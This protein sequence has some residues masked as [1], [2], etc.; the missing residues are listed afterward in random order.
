MINPFLIW[1]NL[2][3]N[4]IEYIDTGLPIRSGYYR[5]RR[6]EILLK[7]HAL[8][9]E[10][11]LELI[12][13]YEGVATIEEY[14]RS[15]GLPPDIAGYLSISLCG[16]R[17]LYQHQIKALDE[18]CVNGKNIVLATGTGSGKTECFLMP[19]L[20][21]LIEE[22]QGWES[23]KTKSRKRGI[24]ALILYPLNALAEDQ[25]VRLRKALESDEA[26]RWLDN[27]RRGN[28]FYFGRY[29]SAT[30]RDANDA[31]YKKAAAQ[32]MRFKE[33][34]ACDESEL[35]NYRY[36]LQN[37]DADSVE[38]KTRKEMQKAAPDIFIT[39]YSMLNVLLMRSKDVDTIFRQT[40][41]WLEEREDNFLT[42]VLDEL[43]TYRGT[44]GT[45]VSYLLRTLLDR[46]GIA[47]KPHKVR[48][49]ASSASINQDDSETWSFL[50][51]FF[52]TD[53]RDSFEIISD[54]DKRLDA[55]PPSKLPMEQLAEI[56]KNCQAKKSQHELEAYLQDALKKIGFARANDF[57]ARYDVKAWL[58]WC[59]GYGKGKFRA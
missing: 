22:S 40:K 13:K 59:L 12:R 19:L 6:K 53:A 29:T 56:G 55:S 34:E 57:A 43:H 28:R 5:K 2:L 15:R 39:N 16:D 44:A 27:N 37:F 7:G 3:D 58:E 21:S 54:S 23:P 51:D 41:E 14:C 30:L 47:G 42:I 10:P 35:G 36:Y 11:Y 48:Y 25:M 31:D 46:L 18:A 17:R 49:I 33:T 52:Y 24:R 8:M 4:Y 20:A 1:R 26:K 50:S 45:E 38:I 9:Q 32:W